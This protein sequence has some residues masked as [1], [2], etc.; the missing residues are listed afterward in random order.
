[1]ILENLLI[2]LLSLK[3]DSN[4]SSFKNLTSHLANTAA[5]FI[6]NFIR[7]IIY[8]KMSKADQMSKSSKDSHIL[9]LIRVESDI[10]LRITNDI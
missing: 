10:G 9:H 3:S 4:D 8:F 2:V 6:P 5:S 7:K 1:M